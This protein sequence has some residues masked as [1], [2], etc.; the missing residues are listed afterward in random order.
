MLS[1]ILVRQVA[2]GAQVSLPSSPGVP[3][4]LFIGFSWA[5]VAVATIF[6]GARLYTRFQTSP[7]LHLDDFFIS[8]AYV[9]VV[10]TASLW[11]WNASEMYY[12]LNVNAGLAAAEADIWP[13]TRRWLLVSFL[14]ELFFY[15]TLILFKLSM[16]F[17]FR[18]IGTIARTFKYIWWPVLIFSLCT[19]VAAAGNIGHK[20]LFGNLETITVYCNSPS[21]TSHLKITL[22][23]NCA[24]DVLSDFLIMLIPFYLLW[25][26]RIRLAKKIAFLGIFS[27]SIVTMGIA[28]A[29]ATEVGATQKSNGLIDS[30][31]LWFW[32]ALQS[33]LC[34]VVACSSA[35]RQLFV[36]TPTVNNNPPW[37]PTS[38]FYDRR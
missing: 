32:S 12:I 10:I 34:I 24:L 37:K 16:L 19:Y 3:Y 35:F 18:R 30:T 20:C 27:L 36:S 26:V 8:F 23:V 4:N 9:L 14:V 17:F 6:V 21:G 31:Y 11:Q 29:R 33:S 7:K 15:T 5:G 22:D 28:I 13:R 1:A 2:E 25:N 38:S